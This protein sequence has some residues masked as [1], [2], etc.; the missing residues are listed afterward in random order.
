MGYYTDFE[1]TIEP[2]L[3][4]YDEGEGFH[5]AFSRET[6]YT[7]DNDFRLLYAK[8]YNY[9]KDM[10]ALSTQYPDRVFTVDGIGEGHGE[11]PDVWRRYYMNG[12]SQDANSRVVVD[13][14]DESLLK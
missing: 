14:F 2:S 6:G 8:W 11:G 4:S 10:L 12:K 13:S 7:I 5:E 1:I 3:Y 9:H